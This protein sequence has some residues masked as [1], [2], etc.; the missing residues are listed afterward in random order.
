VTPGKRPVHAT[1]NHSRLLGDF[2][3]TISSQQLLLLLAKLGLVPTALVLSDEAAREQLCAFR[4]GWKVPAFTKVDRM[5]FCFDLV[6]FLV[7]LLESN[8]RKVR[9]F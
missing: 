4:V 9:K 6:R 7:V 3:A 1:H 8:E 5:D 2:A